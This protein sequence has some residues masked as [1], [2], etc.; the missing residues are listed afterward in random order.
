MANVVSQPGEFDEIEVD[1][2][3]AKVGVFAIYDAMLFRAR[4]A[5]PRASASAGF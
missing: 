2:V 1:L 5:R 4:F 3:S